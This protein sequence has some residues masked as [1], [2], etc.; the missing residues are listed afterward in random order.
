MLIEK[1]KNEDKSK[2]DLMHANC[3]KLV[4]P[5]IQSVAPKMKFHNFKIEKKI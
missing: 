2:K 3:S 1:S 5:K 4:I